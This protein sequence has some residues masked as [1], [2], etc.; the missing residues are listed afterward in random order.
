L[1]N[2]IQQAPSAI[3]MACNLLCDESMISK[4]KVLPFRFATAYEE[5]SKLGSS[6]D[7]RKVLVAINKAL[8]ISA[9]NVP[10]FDGET[11]VVLDVSG[12]DEW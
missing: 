12:S 8:D 2:I 9:I 6:S 10:K 7:V 11:L 3:D 5:I 1:R 4:S